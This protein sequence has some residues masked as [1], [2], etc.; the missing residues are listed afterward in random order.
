MC[1]TASPRPGGAYD[2]ALSAG[3]RGR[4]P[5]PPRAGPDR[6]PTPTLFLLPLFGRLMGPR[7]CKQSPGDASPRADSE[8]RP[9]PPPQPT[10]SAR[11]CPDPCATGSPASATRHAPR[12]S[13]LIMILCVF[14]AFES[15]I[16]CALIRRALSPDAPCGG[17]PRDPAGGARRPRPRYWPRRPGWR[18]RP[19][20]A[21]AGPPSRPTS[22]PR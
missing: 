21:P 1:G 4:A 5:P 17:A 15:V 2:P 14:S 20:P 22:A 3:Y 6:H 10:A 19:P 11:P 7:P 12:P 9:P 18:S 16:S 8:T 13:A